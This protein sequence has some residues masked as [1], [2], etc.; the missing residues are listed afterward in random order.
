MDDVPDEP[1]EKL[2][3]PEGSAEGCASGECLPD[4]TPVAAK[5][6]EAPK[7]VP[8]EAPRAAE[9][10]RVVAAPKP[11]EAPKPA[12]T[13]RV[14]EAP[15]A[16]ELPKPAIAPRTVDAR[17]AAPSSLIEQWKVAVEAVR[18]AS[19]RHGKSLSH[20]RFVSMEPGTVRIA[21]PNDAAFHRSTV[22]GMS[23]QLIEEVLTKHFGRP[24]KV[25]E[26]NTSQALAAAA[27][28]IAE[29]EAKET[30]AR[31]TAI[32][33]HVAQHP[34]IR[35]VLRIL[36]GTVEHVQYLEPVREAPSLVPVASVPDDE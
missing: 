16:V 15:K 3:A 34:A 2:F 10:P 14:V 30:A 24:T 7:V 9:A 21:F 18:V 19:P 31:H 29:D 32:D 23:R 25:A 12:A 35:N 33:A 11:A 22:F 17:P 26:D 20:G 4:G 8:V 1:E 13:P 28:S 6:V 36:G 27:P 5:P